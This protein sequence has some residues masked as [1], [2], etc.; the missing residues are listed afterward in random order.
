MSNP[1]GDN[2]YQSPEPI[3]M[4]ELVYPKKPFQQP[5]S[6]QKIL[7]VMAILVVYA[8]IIGLSITSLR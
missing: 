6:W 7:F 4:A 5:M 8:V 2:P 1:F 3:V